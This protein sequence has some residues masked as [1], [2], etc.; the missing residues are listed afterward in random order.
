MGCASKGDNS[1]QEGGNG[2]STVS[3]EGTASGLRVGGFV[4]SLFPYM[5][6][7]DES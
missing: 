1:N 2:C 7:C 4:L 5:L 3:W 6:A